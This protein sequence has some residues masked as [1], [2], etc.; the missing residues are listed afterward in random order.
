MTSLTTFPGKISEPG[1]H[2]ASS[3]SRSAVADADRTATT[4]VGSRKAFVK[5]ISAPRYYLAGSDRA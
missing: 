5:R 3:R 2:F 1:W 4:I